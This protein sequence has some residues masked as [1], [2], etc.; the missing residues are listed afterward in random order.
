MGA[1]KTVST[2]LTKYQISQTP[3][4]T[5]PSW[6]RFVFANFN[7]ID[8]LEHVSWRVWMQILKRVPG[9]ILWLLEP[10][11][12]SKK[13]EIEETLYAEATAA[14]VH[15]RRIIFAPRRSKRFHIARFA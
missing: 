3:S 11:E 1:P 9:S 4:P 13:S 6:A 14:G 2:Q 5:P 8:K 15:R 7:K 10:S 12:A